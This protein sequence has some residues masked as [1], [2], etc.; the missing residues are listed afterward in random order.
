M[1]TDASAPR[2][3][4]RRLVARTA[5]HRDAPDSAALAVHAAFE[6]TYRELTR[7]LGPTGSYALLSRALAQSQAEHTL[8]KDI[9]VDRQ[10]APALGGVTALVTVHGA[11][12]VESGLQA[13]LE[14]VLDLLGRLIGADMVARLVEQ[15]TSMETQDDEDLK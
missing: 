12:A 5:P 7:S 11:S 13:V 4:A 6:R 2:E 9:R 8:L 14:T 1:S 15:S 3:L 10:S